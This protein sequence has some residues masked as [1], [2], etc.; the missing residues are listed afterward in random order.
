VATSFP[1]AL[2]SYI[3][4]TGT[5][6]LDDA[7]VLHSAQHSNINDAVEAIEAKVGIDFSSVTNTL[8]FIT[9]LLL[10][11]WLQHQD[12]GYRE[13]TYVSGNPPIVSTVIWYTTSAKTIK[14]V[15]KIYTY[16]SIKI[17]PTVVTLKLYDGTIANVLKRTITDTIIYDRVFETSRS[18]IIT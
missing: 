17:L 12:G 8:D 2:D 3:N 16:G 6:H 10:M 11:T 18:R 4:P 9:K 1:T 15:E 7:P 14:L 13:I 5:N